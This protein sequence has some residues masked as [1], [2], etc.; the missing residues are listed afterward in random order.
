MYNLLCMLVLIV[1]YQGSVLALPNGAPSGACT[2]MAPRHNDGSGGLYSAQPHSS[3]VYTIITDKANY[4]VNQEV[5]VWIA[6]SRTGADRGYKGI[7]LQARVPDGTAPLGIW[8]NPPTNTKMI[9]CSSAN[10]T[11]THSN[12][13]DKNESNV[14][15]WKPNG[16]SADVQFV[17]TVAQQK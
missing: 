1:A 6:D 7:M 8:M 14:F 12:T 4:S 5:R 13:M 15:T 3:S 17:L 9:M 16:T 11:I 2:S 10:D